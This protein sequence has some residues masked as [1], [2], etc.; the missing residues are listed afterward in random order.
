M[1]H[2]GKIYNFLSYRIA[3]RISEKVNGI[4]ETYIWLLSSIGQP[5]DRPKVISAQV[6]LDGGVKLKEIY[7]EIEDTIAQE[8]DHLEEF[9]MD[10]AQGKISIS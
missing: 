10:L 2:V 9:C 4:K 3:E 5:I 8:F 1:Y 6:I 7:P